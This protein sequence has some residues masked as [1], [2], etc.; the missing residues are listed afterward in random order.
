MKNIWLLL[1]LCS[2]MSSQ[3]K[4]QTLSKQ[5]V[6][7]LSDIK[8]FAVM[9]IICSSMLASTELEEHLQLSL[10]N[11]GTVL[12]QQNKLKMG[13][14][15]LWMGNIEEGLRDEKVDYFPVIWVSLQAVNSVEVLENHAQTMGII[16]RADAYFEQEDTR[17][18]TTEKAKKYIDSLVAQFANEYLKANG[19]TL[20]PQFYLAN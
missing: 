3:E 6:Q 2:C 7:P 9:P 17:E 5:K 11:F 1:L 4:V 13:A 18:K 15:S 8:N 19:T 20:Q 14:L 16:W 12:P 10:N